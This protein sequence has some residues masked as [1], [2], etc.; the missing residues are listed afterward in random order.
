MAKFK[1]YVNAAFATYVGSFFGA[2][3][4]D[5]TYMAY[6]DLNN[7]GVIDTK[8]VGA[9]AQKVD[10]WVTVDVKPATLQEWFGDRPPLLQRA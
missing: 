3:K 10:T 6:M 2:K 1:I 7:D 5:D 8:D 9:W 4:G